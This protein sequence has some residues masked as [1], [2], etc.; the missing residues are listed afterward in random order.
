MSVNNEWF[1]CLG[2]K[3]CV[4]PDHRWLVDKHHMMTLML[5]QTDRASCETSAFKTGVKTFPTPT[6]LAKATAPSLWRWFQLIFSSF[7]PMFSAIAAPRASPEEKHMV[8]NSLRVKTAALQSRE[9]GLV[10]VFLCDCVPSG[11]AIRSRKYY[12]LLYLI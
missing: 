9:L 1:Y 8:P 2:S 5:V 7:N 4:I 3:A 12:Y 10:Q 11:Q 6:P